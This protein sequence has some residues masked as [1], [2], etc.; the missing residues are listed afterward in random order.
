MASIFEQALAATEGME[1]EERRQAIAQKVEELRRAE[2][3]EALGIDIDPV[4]YTAGVKGAAQTI[5][6]AL[7]DPIESIR[8][9][10][11][12]QAPQPAAPPPKP[13]GPL[14][15]IAGTAAQQIAGPQ[16]AGTPDIAR[17]LGG[18]MGGG[19]GMGGLSMPSMDPLRQA[20]GERIETMQ[21]G[22]EAL[23]VGYEEMREAQGAVEQAQMS[24]ADRQAT[25]MSENIKAQ[26]LALAD[27]QQ[28]QA[29][30]QLYVRGEI[31][32]VRDEM[33]MIR[34]SGVDPLNF[35]KHPD[36][37]NNLGKSIMAAIAVSFGAIGQAMKGGG[38]NSALQ[39]TL[40]SEGLVPVPLIEI[41]TRRKPTSRIDARG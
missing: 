3:K 21:Q 40:S 35:Y 34:T 37:S 28:R 11:L 2:G 18:A 22:E 41:L 26:E 12:A 19:M 38:P 29:E 5:A 14:G 20:M 6:G 10:A 13:T 15:Q 39:I 9:E 24:A 7:G 8:Q 32:K 16:F 25:A 27:Q 4:D 23:G 30:R 33:D 1:G 31:D 36:G 17:Q